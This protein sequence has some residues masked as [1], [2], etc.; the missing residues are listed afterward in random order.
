MTGQF[1]QYSDYVPTGSQLQ[2]PAQRP[3]QVHPSLGLEV[4]P[5]ERDRAERFLADAYADGRVNEFEFDSR[6]EQVLRART[7]KDLNTAFYGL[8]DVPSTS[9]ALGL[10]P[11]Y[12]PNLVRQDAG[13]KTGR[14]VAAFAHFSPFFSWIVGPLLVNLV[15][16]PGSF[17]KRESAKA[18]N[19]QL[20]STLLL[21][22]AGIANG[23]A[24][25]RFAWLI[26]VGWIVWFFVTI[27]G[28]VMAAQGRDWE[29]PAS[30]V[31]R[32]Q[33]LKEK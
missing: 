33:V 1:P 24:D 18:F 22:V 9:R 19:F 14:G 13:S 29:N 2:P 10:H 8:V 31:L 32:L 5:E 12:H 28:G 11:A 15:S 20:N 26:G 7:R 6:M 4:T 17:A 25:D 27:V 21:V 30:K 23:I 3:P 16:S